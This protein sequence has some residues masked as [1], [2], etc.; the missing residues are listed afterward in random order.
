MLTNCFWG[1][2][3]A[4]HFHVVIFNTSLFL[5][6]FIVFALI[7]IIFFWEKNAIHWQNLYILSYHVGES[8]TQSIYSLLSTDLVL[9]PNDS[10]TWQGCNLLIRL[11][12]LLDLVQL[13]V[14]VLMNKTYMGL[15]SCRATLTW[16]DTL[17][18]M[19]SWLLISCFTERSVY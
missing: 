14:K 9:N 15:S 4:K 8:L 12:N 7:L 10:L 2:W 18:L 6:Q 13:A 17:N 3:L 5:S 1:R 19:L 16:E 11:L